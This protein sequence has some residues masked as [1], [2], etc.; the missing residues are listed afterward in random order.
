MKIYNFS[1]KILITNNAKSASTFSDRVLGLL[2]P[3]N[4]RFLIIHTHFG[5]HTLFMNVPIDIIVLDSSQK[6][7]SIRENLLPNRIHFYHPKFS[8]VIELPQGSIGK[9]HIGINDKISIE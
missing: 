8:T 6:I 3:K 5:I 7:V 1:K 4:P 9:F 2:N